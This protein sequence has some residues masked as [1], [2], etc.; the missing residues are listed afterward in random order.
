VGAAAV[1]LAATAAV[2]VSATGASSAKNTAVGHAAGVATAT[3]KA[4]DGTL[5]SGTLPSSGT[6]ANGG[7]IVAGQLTGQ[8]PT[9]ISP[10]ISSAVCSSD[11]FQFVSDMYIPLY[12]GPTGGTPAIDASLGAAEPAK[13]SNGDKTVK[14][15]IKP[16]LKWSDGSPVNGE[17][18][19]F[20]YYLLKAA[21]TA[22]PA[23]WCQYSSSTQFPFNVKSISYSGNTVTM[24]LKGSVNP[25]WFID[26]QLQDTNGGVYPLPVTDWNVNSSGQHLTD[27]ATNPKDALAIYQNITN[28]NGADSPSQFATSPLWKVVDG[29]YK[30]K[31]FDATNSSFV[32]T[33]NSSYGLSPKPTATFEDNTYTSSTALVDAMESGSVEIG[34][35][36]PGS[37]LPLIPTLK[38]K[39]FSVFG[40]PEWGWFGGF[41]NF[42]DTTNHFNKVIAQPYMRGVMAELTNESAIAKDVWHGWAVPAYGPVASAPSSPYLSAASTKANYP[43]SPKKAVATLKAHGWSVKPGGQTTCAKAGSG[44]KD[45]GAGIPKGTPIK[46]VWADQPE[47]AAATGVEEATVF[48]TEAK[49]AAGINVTLQTKTFNFLTQ[50]YN[51]QNPAAK[52]YQNDWGVNNYGGINTDYYPTEDGV[53]NT[54]GALNMGYYNDAKANQLMIK[55]TTSPSLA[56][57]G[58]EVKYFAQQMPVLYMPVQDWITGVSSKIGGTK[59]G[60]LQMTQQE[61]NAT[62]LWVKK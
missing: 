34:Q 44:A 4:M 21:A 37:Q 28:T 62:L 55:S 24:N 18:V 57:I 26:N 54:N 7:T 16:G 56:A 32:L 39:G 13:F 30:L 42:K 40:A 51:D 31:S 10:I 52:K 20:D 5:L 14:I 3:P 15:T 17:D 8:T 41:F 23:N 29:G 43:Y 61:L 58:N 11:T 59:D 9:D 27:W 53:M 49:Q 6:A 48:S 19:A 1:T 46:F 2:A 45:C 25:T 60:F 35:I 50:F 22:S 38:G 36:D 12:Y 47:S 33:P